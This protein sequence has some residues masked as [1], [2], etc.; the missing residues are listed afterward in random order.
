MIIGW[1]R[2]NQSNY[3]PWTKIFVKDHLF[4]IAHRSNGGLYLEKPLGMFWVV[5]LFYKLLS[6]LALAIL[7]LRV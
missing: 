7:P 3:V 1:L 4:L 6:Y 5:A 2:G